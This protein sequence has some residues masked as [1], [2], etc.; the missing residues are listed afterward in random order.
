MFI[1]L[2]F[3]CSKIEPVCSDCVDL[4]PCYKAPFPVN[5]P[6]TVL[7]STDCNLYALI[8]QSL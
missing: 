8:H 4:I 6:L 1:F 3:T 2:I 5:L 7:A